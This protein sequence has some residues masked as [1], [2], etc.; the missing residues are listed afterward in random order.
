M[1]SSSQADG[2]IQGVSQP[3]AMIHKKV[4]EVARSDPDASLESIADE[5]GGA[6]AAFVER[7]LEEYGD[8]AAE[9][10]DQRADG[11]GSSQSSSEVGAV[12]AP[13]QN[14]SSTGTEQQRE[15]DPTHSDTDEQN[16]MAHVNQKENASKSSEGGSS[17]T[18]ISDDSESPTAP[19][20]V[21][22]TH[23][24][25]GSSAD[26][27][28][29]DASDLESATIPSELSD[30][31]LE[32]L[33]SV[34]QDPTATQEEIADKLGVTRAT[35]SKRLNNISG[36]NW[37]TRRRFVDKLFDDDQ[38]ADSKSRVADNNS[39]S[40]IMELESRIDELE[41]Q[42]EKASASDSGSPLDP[43]L[44]RKVVHSCMHADYLSEDEEFE[45][46]RKLL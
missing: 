14:G 15:T 9:S 28:I 45:L 44:T 18:E 24:A 30:K 40:Q 41:A 39:Q 23:V 22:N 34:R 5:V 27:Q 42:L 20:S 8:P 7:V 36:F 32:T 6:S 31:Q 25:G 43:D 3:R 1:N 37:K 16:Q 33:R 29:T 26:S 19:E 46:L 11:K 13:S 35:I 12:S 21:N 38:L 10:S 17:T 2:D 4:L